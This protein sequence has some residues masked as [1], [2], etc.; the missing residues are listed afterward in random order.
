MF[1]E[2]QG[3]EFFEKDAEKEYS[4]VS[5]DKTKL[6]FDFALSAS[7]LRDIDS[8]LEKTAYF[9]CKILDCDRASIFIWDKKKK[10]LWSKVALGLDEIIELEPDK[11]IVGFVFSQKRPVI[12][13]DPYS[14]PRFNPDI[15]KKTGYKTKNIIALPLITY[16]GNIVG[17]IEGIN[18]FEEEFDEEDIKF[19]QILSTYA[20]N[21][22]ENAL[23]YSEIKRTQEEIVVRL[24][25]AAEFRDKTT[26]NHLVRMSIYSYLIAKEMGF[27][28]EWCEKLRLAAPMHDIG[29]LGVPDRILLKPSKLTDEEFKEMQKHTIYGYDILKDS[30]IDILKMG[31][32]IALCHHERYDGKG[33]PRG[34]KGEE[35]PIEARIVALADVVDALLSRRPYKEPF[36]I[37]EVVDFVKKESGKHFDPKVVSA[38]LRIIPQVK[39]VLEKYGVD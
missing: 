19:A 8:V 24:S 11:G 14:D 15:D 16:S 21:S 3:A 37:D 25:I 38:F 5:S 1:F 18:K 10:K 20:A 7:A 13:N 31:A 22:I 4:G 39:K 36:G 9:F 32:N 35:I 27:D 33:Y 2:E 34:L 23:L 30:D 6:L 29:K 17:V 12:I 26:Y 28:E